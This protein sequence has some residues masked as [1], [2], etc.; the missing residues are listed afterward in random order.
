M[1][2]ETCVKLETG[3]LDIKF[4]LGFLI[5]N[6]EISNIAFKVKVLIHITQSL[7]NLVIQSL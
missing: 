5:R 7:F 4:M 6:H 2:K 3:R 1:D